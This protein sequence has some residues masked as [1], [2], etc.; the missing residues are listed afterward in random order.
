MN[1]VIM[2]NHKISLITSS[3]TDPVFYDIILNIYLANDT[4]SFTTVLN[5]LTP[6]RL[7][8]TTEQKMVEFKHKNK[9]FDQ[10][11]LKKN[12]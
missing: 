9:K 8:L 5:L 7:H 12:F 4:V 10:I 6:G 1:H 3:T 11:K 2:A